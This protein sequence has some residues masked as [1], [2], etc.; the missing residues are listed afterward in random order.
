MLMSGTPKHKPGR[1]P[2]LV[3]T[4]QYGTRYPQ[5]PSRAKLRLWARAALRRNARVTLRLIGGREARRLNRDYRG[6]DYATNVLTFIYSKRAPLEGDIAICAPVVARE[7]RLAGVRRAAH[8]AH[9][10]VHGM[11]HLQGHD[12]ARAA[13][14]RRMEKLEARILARLGYADP[15]GRAPKKTPSARKHGR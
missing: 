13:D 4:V 11:L 14:A 3:L 8:Y 5:Q 12:H 9:L 1:T 7:A 6:R 2:E 10:T 15:Y